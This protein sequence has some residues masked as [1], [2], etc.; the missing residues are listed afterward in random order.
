MP[1]VDEVELVGGLAGLKILTG[2]FSYL[3]ADLISN[4]TWYTLHVEDVV[5]GPTGV[6]GPR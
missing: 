6:K 1:S 3:S 4:S 5:K 2:E